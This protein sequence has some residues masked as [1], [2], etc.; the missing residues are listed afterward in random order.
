MK[1]WINCFALFVL[2]SSSIAYSHSMEKIQHTYVLVHG[3]TGGGW[4]WKLI[5]NLLSKDGHEVYRPTLTG[6]GERMHLG[7]SDINLSTHV[8]DIV[9]LIKFEQLENIILVGHS[10]GGM[11]I[12]GVMNELPEKIQHAFFLDA[13]VPD[14]GMSAIDVAGKYIN[15]PTKNGLYIRLGWTISRP[16]LAI[17]PIQRRL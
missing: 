1:A 15:F 14:H 12:T 6:L 10:Y 16:F 13:L 8:E 3:M 17:Y 11:V 5:D 7:H 2:F 4:D 9:N